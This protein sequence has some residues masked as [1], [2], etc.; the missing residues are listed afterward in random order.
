MIGVQAYQC[1]GAESQSSDVME[2]YEVSTREKRLK[3]KV[4]FVKL[5]RKS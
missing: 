2:K 5:I 3:D 1:I 4:K